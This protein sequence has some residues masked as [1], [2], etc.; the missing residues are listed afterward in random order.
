M[1]SELDIME[2]MVK[3]ITEELN[4]HLPEG[5]ES[6]VEGQVILD[7]PDP[8][9]MPYPVMIYVF[10]DYVEYEEQTTESD[11]GN[12]RLTVFILC[13]RDSRY[14][15]TVKTHGYYNALYDLL[16]TNTTLGALVD[17]TTVESATFYPAVDANRDIKGAEADVR[18]EY[19]LDF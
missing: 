4:D 3:V 5:L 13:K 15:L 11:R 18:T 6:I 7:I 17:F 12:F 16:R 19:E 10:P 2:Q 8:D 14:N 1:I 9:Q